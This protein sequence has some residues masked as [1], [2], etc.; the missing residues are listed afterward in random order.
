M[1]Y[2]IFDVRAQGQIPGLDHDIYI[3]S[4]GPG[5]P[6]KEEKLWGPAF[7]RLL[8]DL[9]K[10]NHTQPKQAKQVFNICHS[11][12][13]ICLHFGIS[14]VIRR[15]SESFGVYPVHK[16]DEGERDPIFKELDDPFY[17]AD[18][19]KYQCIQPDHATIARMGARIIAIEKYRSHVQLERALMAIRLSPDWLA[20]QFHPE[21]HVAGM[22]EHFY[23][24]AVKKK[25]IDI[26][27]RDKYSKMI[28][29]LG[30]ENKLQKTQ[31]IVL[32]GFLAGAR[33]KILSRRGAFVT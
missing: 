28:E 13:M 1:Q 14:R 7:H 11:F 25:I 12:Q 19:R 23:K 26:R 21:A 33:E 24:R 5:D 6:R 9:W 15:R 2:E 30:D 32:P 16:T 27:G 3:F 22:L 18:F 17:A 20:V 4:G 29:D 31:S 10:F 8:D